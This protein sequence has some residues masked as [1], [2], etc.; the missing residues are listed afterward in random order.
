MKRRL[1]EAMARAYRG[2]RLDA[3]RETGLPLRTFPEECPYT[4]DE[5]LTRDFPIDPKP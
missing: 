4:R 2:A 1:D 3:S 5:M